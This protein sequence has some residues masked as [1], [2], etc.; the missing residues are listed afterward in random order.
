LAETDGEFVATSIGWHGEPGFW[1]SADGETWVRDDVATQGS[2]GAIA[3]SVIAIDN[4]YF[5]VG[6]RG[7]TT[8]DS[9]M[10]VWHGVPA[11]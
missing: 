7:E 9:T 3:G 4:A 11:P 1:T 2:A 5:G 10:V 8:E 6:S